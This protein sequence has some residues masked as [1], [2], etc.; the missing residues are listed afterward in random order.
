MAFRLAV[1]RFSSTVHSQMTKADKL[2]LYKK[3]LRAAAVFPS[4]TRDGMIRDIKVS[5]TPTSSG[6]PF[7]FLFTE[8]VIPI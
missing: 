6:S 3:I 4:I 2:I 5:F 8:E 7:F 1:R